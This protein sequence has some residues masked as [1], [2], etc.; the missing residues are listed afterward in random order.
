MPERSKRIT[1]A[2]F[3]FSIFIFL[4]IV[5]FVVIFSTA[6]STGNYSR[7]TTMSS[8]EC[9]G[10]TFRVIPNTIT[11]EENTLSFV[12]DSVGGGSVTQLV[13]TSGGEERETPE[14]D[15]RGR[16]KRKI[17]IKDIEFEGNFTIYPKGCKNYNMKQCSLEECVIIR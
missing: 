2:I 13:I 1:I 5:V 15:F 6:R 3:L 12:I 17:T 10:I 11:Y 7:M 16:V 9:L 8:V 4:G 14:V